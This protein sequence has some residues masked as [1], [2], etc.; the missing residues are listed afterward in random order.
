VV[1]IVCCWDENLGKV[2]EAQTGVPADDFNEGCSFVPPEYVD[3][4]VEELLALDRLSPEDVHRLLEAG[5][6]NISYGIAF[7]CD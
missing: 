7:G 4:V 2:V 6:N 5:G 3:R 1:E